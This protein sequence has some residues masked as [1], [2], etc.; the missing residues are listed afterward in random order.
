MVMLTNTSF[1]KM[2]WNIHSNMFK[3]PVFHEIKNAAL[4]FARR[5]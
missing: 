3:N 5:C 1:A 4:G 2:P